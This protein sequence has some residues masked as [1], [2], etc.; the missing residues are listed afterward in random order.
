MCVW[1]GGPEKCYLVYA[2]YGQICRNQQMDNNGGKIKAQISYRTGIINVYMPHTPVSIT[3]QHHIRYWLL[4]HQASHFLQ[5]AEHL[6]EKNATGLLLEGVLQEGAHIPL[7]TSSNLLFTLYSGQN[8]PRTQ[9]QKKHLQLLPAAISMATIWFHYFY[10]DPMVP[11]K[12]FT[13]KRA[14]R[15]QN[16]ELPLTDLRSVLVCRLQTSFDRSFTL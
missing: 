1:G 3:P 7:T 2:F 14:T 11:L 5:A 13:L 4:H 15:P 8:T 16:L 6:Q 10:W 12:G 9:Q